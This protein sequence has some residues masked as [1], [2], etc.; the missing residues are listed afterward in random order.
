[1]MP[2]TLSELYPCEWLKHDDLNGRSFVLT[3]ASVEIRKFEHGLR[4]DEY[5]AVLSF[6]KAEKRLICNKT[7]ATAVSEIAQTEVFG[8]WPGTRITLTP[9]MARNKKPTI[10]ITPAPVK[11]PAAADE[12]E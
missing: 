1:M 6:E 2:R 4:P 10:I 5:S 7:Q 11:R 9:G 3:I 8:D 12:E